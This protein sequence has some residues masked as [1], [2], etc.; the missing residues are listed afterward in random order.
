[1]SDRLPRLRTKNIWIPLLL[2]IVLIGGMVIGFYLN[3]YLGNKRDFATI[4]DRNDRLEEMID[5]IHEK[6]V[7]SVSSDS[8]YND[9]I[10]GILSH[11][12]P[13][14]SYI[15]AKDF[16]SVNAN[17]EGNFKGIGMEYQIVR[18]TPM[19]SMIALNSP[20]F[21]AGIETGDLLLKVNDTLVAGV[22]VSKAEL[23]K[24]VRKNAAAFVNVTLF[25]PIEQRTLT[26][27]VQKGEV[28]VGSIDAGYMLDKE[29]GYIKIKRFSANTYDEFLK[30]ITYLK[31][32]GMK[33]LIVDV[34]QNGGG[35]L[36]AATEIADEFINGNKLLVYTYGS[37][38]GRENYNAYR[39]GIF[40]TGRLMVMVDEA[41]ASA[42]E[43]LA[44]A[45]QDWDR[46]VIIGRNTYGK[47]LVQEQFEMGDGAAMRITV[48]RY[49]TPV[50]RSIQRSY[51]EGRDK[52][53]WEQQQS[54]RDLFDSMALKTG[55]KFYTSENNR[56][57]YGGGGIQPDVAVTKD[58]ESYS[59]ILAKIINDPRLDQFIYQYF[60]SNY[61][62]FKSLQ[63]FKDLD[64]RV[65]FTGDLAR[66]LDGVCT[67]ITPQ[68][69]IVVK[70]KPIELRLLQNYV[71][72]TWARILYNNEGYYKIMNRSDKM[73]MEAQQIINSEAYS[74]II[75]GQRIKPLH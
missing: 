17:L 25:R 43:I 11:L 20:A 53:F 10:S 56:V 40:E 26:L 33:K 35:Y 27:K 21:F 39:N 48:A 69:R 71:K 73:L 58:E 70:L 13:H 46:G 49:Y 38:I 51:E 16:E 55:P 12:D 3:K 57:V 74:K 30:S 67:T 72:A 60:L 32:S 9:A 2:A 1:M 24:K 14:T 4:L 42:S 19:V 64:A 62:V 5:I 47:G 31:E 52:Y 66:Q 23:V 50:G 37:K 36:E 41:S 22:N 15:P 54:N 18:D 44:G 61:K 28:P 8:L 68:Y 75:N 59:P 63:S 45:I 7:D 6:Y 65:D 29:T 34:R